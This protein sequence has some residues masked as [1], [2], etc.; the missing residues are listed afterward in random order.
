[1]DK[2]WGRGTTKDGREGREKGSDLSYEVIDKCTSAVLHPL[3]V[4]YRSCYGCNYTAAI[5]EGEG[6]GDAERPVKREG[7]IRA[8]TES[9]T[10]VF[11]THVTCA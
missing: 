9:I 2:C 5:V 4:H 1:M 6:K 10:R 11:L 3:L 7:D 8:G